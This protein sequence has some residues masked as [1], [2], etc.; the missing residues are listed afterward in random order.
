MQVRIEDNTDEQYIQLAL[1]LKQ[2][3]K[4]VVC[5]FDEKL[6][7]QTCNPASPHYDASLDLN[8]LSEHLQQWMQLLLCMAGSQE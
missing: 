3:T 8:K 7:L 4:N 1:K 6:L 5:S 2:V